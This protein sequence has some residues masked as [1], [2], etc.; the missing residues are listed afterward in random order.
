MWVY[1]YKFLLI[2]T[3]RGSES[4]KHSVWR[5]FFV[6]VNCIHGNL[7]YSIVSGNRFCPSPVIE[8]R[9]P[10]RRRH[11]H[12]SGRLRRSAAA[13]RSCPSLRCSPPHPTRRERC[14]SGIC[15]R[16]MS[17]R[18]YRTGRRRSLHCLS[19]GVPR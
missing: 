15:L 3:H 6:S 12:C 18:H 8:C 9:N 17:P 2:L 19:T 7:G 16:N 11:R 1:V 14:R 4:N 10:Q 13:G 5:N